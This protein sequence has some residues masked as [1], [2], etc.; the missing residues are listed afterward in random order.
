MVNSLM[1]IQGYISTMIT[2][3]QGVRQGGILSMDIFKCGAN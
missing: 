1:M 2:A 3:V